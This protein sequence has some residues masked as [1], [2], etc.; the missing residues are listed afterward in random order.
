[1]RDL[2]LGDLNFSLPGHITRKDQ[3]PEL[4]RDGS[5]GSGEKEIIVH[6]SKVAQ[7]IESFD[8]RFK[9]KKFSFPLHAGFMAL[10]ENHHRNML[11]NAKETCRRRAQ[12]PA[13]NG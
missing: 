10:C 2:A 7:R 11:L 1:L 3:V 8:S 9:M 4:E 6:L 13:L 5:L 12:L